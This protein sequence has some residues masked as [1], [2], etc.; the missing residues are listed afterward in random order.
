MGRGSEFL[1]LREDDIAPDVA[2]GI[3]GGEAD[4]T[5]QFDVFLLD[6]LVGL[7]VWEIR[8][9]ETVGLQDLIKPR[10]ELLWRPPHYCLYSV[11][12]LFH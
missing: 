9:L 8:V 1:F 12:R 10:I 2:E 11:F 4:F 5:E 7:G 3:V 6:Y